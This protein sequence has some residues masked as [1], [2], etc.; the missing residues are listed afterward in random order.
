MPSEAFLRARE[1]HLR[2]IG[3]TDLLGEEE[4]EHGGLRDAAWVEAELAKLEA[5]ET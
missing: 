5:E 3:R 1:A 4:P 2:A